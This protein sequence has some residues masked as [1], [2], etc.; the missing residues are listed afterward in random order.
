[1]RKAIIPPHLHCRICGKAIPPEKETCS[2]ECRT[3]EKN[4]Q[5]RN[6]KMSRIYLI[7][8]VTMIAILMSVTLLTAP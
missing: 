1:M 5:S 8:F 3:K 7:I 4:T 2:N 6:K